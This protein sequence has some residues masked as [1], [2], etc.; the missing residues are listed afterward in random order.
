MTIV[1]VTSIKPDTLACETQVLCVAR[2]GSSITSRQ[3]FAYTSLVG[4][5]HVQPFKQA[6]TR[7]AAK[8]WRPSN[9]ELI[10]LPCGSDLLIR[11]LER[12][13]VCLPAFVADR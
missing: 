12:R 8:S 3:V 2:D 4:K 13:A 1:A 6:A 9:A 5:D 11:V 7:H 10:S